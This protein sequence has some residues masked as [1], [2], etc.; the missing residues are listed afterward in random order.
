FDRQLW[1]RFIR[2]AQPYFFP[3]GKGNTV[4][5]F[6]LLAVM[7][8]AV[9][10]FTF[11]LTIG[12]TFL[13][14]VIFPDSFFD[15]VA[16]EFSGQI[17]AFIAQKLHIGAAAVL[18]TCLLIFGLHSRQLKGRWFQWGMLTFSVFLLFAVNGLNVSL[19]FIFRFL[20]T[21]LTLFTGDPELRSAEAAAAEQI[22]AMHQEQFWSFL[23]FYG[24]ILVVAVPILVTY[25]FV[26]R[27]LRLRWREWLTQHFLVRYFDR[28]SYYE[29]DSNASN[30]E[31]DNPDQRISEDTNHF[32]SQT[33]FLILDVLDSILKL[34]SFTAI[35][36][37]ISAQLSY[38][39]GTYALIG[40]VIITLISARLIKI[41]FEQLRL[42]GN[43]R[44]GLVHVRDN[45]EAIAF[46]QGEAPEYS[47][48]S[49][50]LSAAIKNANLLI[51]W[52][53]LV[54]AINRSYNLFARLLPYAFV[55]PMFFAGDVDFGTIGQ[56][57][58]SFFQ[59]FGALSLIADQI[60]LLARF[61]ASIDRLGEF[62]EA[63]DDPAH[64]ADKTETHQI[65]AQDAAGLQVTNLTLRTPNSEQVLTEGLNASLSPGDCLLVVG[66]SG[67]GKSSLMRAIAGLWNNG[68]GTIARPPRAETVFL[69]QKPYMLLGSLR[70]QL[71]YPS[72]PSSYSD[73]DLRGALADVNL[74]ELPDRFE[75]FDAIEDWTDV[76]SLGEQQRLAFARILLS[77][78]KYAIL[79]ESTSAL[80]VTN[81]R[82]LYELLKRKGITY[83]SVGHRPSLLEFHPQVLQLEKQD[84][85]RMYSAAEYREVLVSEM[86]I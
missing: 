39:L 73:E 57:N 5:F 34:L 21:T 44:Y 76:L 51:I 60:E 17:E 48:V 68:T 61:A 80:D 49:S 78:P 72:P 37:R 64:C 19:S 41:N 3:L 77:R 16:A 65:K 2:I 32:V 81:E 69:P 28:R 52:E 84:R 22:Q 46:Y 24:L 13:G 20:D 6:G 53:S 74:E 9:I 7:L 67:C 45:A 8:V 27:Q 66:S 25:S 47:Q 43:F 38:G 36:Y 82:M 18:A 55:A 58:F 59:V 10:A 1:N 62:Y 70:E 23:W 15:T 75:S 85:G 14:K 4:K 63:L 42:E 29:L 33:L 31:I 30:T 86:N 83:I 11:L 56:A 71:T 50:R 40:T 35:L 54:S 12:V 79:D 26:R